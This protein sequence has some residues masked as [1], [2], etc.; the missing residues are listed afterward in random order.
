MING[1]NQYEKLKEK[2]DNGTPKE[3][4]ITLKN[5][6]SFNYALKHLERKLFEKDE[7][8]NK[9]ISGFSV[10]DIVIE[11]NLGLILKAIFSD[12]S[13]HINKNFLLPQMI[14]TLYITSKMNQ[15][16]NNRSFNLAFIL[17]YLSYGLQERRNMKIM[18]LKKFY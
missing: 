6:I 18:T 14:N 9:N 4:D 3:S 2:L 8:K 12:K 1:N 17:Y 10:S 5:S 13:K 16:S 15:K 11:F 7:N